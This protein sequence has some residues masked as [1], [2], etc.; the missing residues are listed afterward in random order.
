MPQG[1][2]KKFIKKRLQHTCFPVNIAEFLRTSIL[3]NICKQT[4]ASI[5]FTINYNIVSHEQR[6]FNICK[7]NPWGE[8]V[9]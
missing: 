7:R 6:V 2:K 5:N 3:G 8:N 1:L 4:I 9:T